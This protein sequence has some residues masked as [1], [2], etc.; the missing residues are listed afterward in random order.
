MGILLLVAVIIGA[1]VQIRRRPARSRDRGHA[2]WSQA[3]AGG[4]QGQPERLRQ[5]RRLRTTPAA[6]DNPGGCGNPGG[7]SNPGGPSDEEKNTLALPELRPRTSSAC[8]TAA[9]PRPTRIV[10]EELERA[11]RQGPPRWRRRRSSDEHGPPR[12]ARVRKALAQ[13][14]RKALQDLPQQPRGSP[15]TSSSSRWLRSARSST[16]GYKD[17]Q[18]GLRRASSKRAPRRQDD[19]A[20]PARAEHR[21]PAARSSV[22]ARREVPQG[23]LGKVGK[24]LGIAGTALSLYDNVNE[25]RRRQGPHRDRRR[26]RRA[27]GGTGAAIT[28]GCAAVGVATAGRRR[29]RLRRRRASAAATSAASTAPRSAGWAYDRG[30]DAGRTPSTTTWSSRS[31]TP[32]RRRRHGGRRGREGSRRQEEGDRGLLG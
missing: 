18:N 28:A 27:R 12:H 24:G 25:R 19:R 14:R 5:P 1:V 30:A 8:L 26:R 6:P 9:P 21:P 4:G 11:R 7:S 22:S 31:P 29:P 13:A 23:R 16:R 20:G 3:I 32:R 15:T 10:R 17:I 2:T